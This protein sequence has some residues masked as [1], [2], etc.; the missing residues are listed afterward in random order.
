MTDEIRI[1][2]FVP[3][4]DPATIEDPLDDIVDGRKIIDLAENGA[5]AGYKIDGLDMTGKRITLP[6][7][8]SLAMNGRNAPGGIRRIWD[9]I[10]DERNRLLQLDP[11]WY[12]TAAAFDAAISAIA[13]IIPKT[14]WFDRLRMKYGVTT[15]TELKALFPNIT[16]ENLAYVVNGAPVDGKVEITVSWTPVDGAVGYRLYNHG[17]GFAES[18]TASYTRQVSVDMEYEIT[19]TAVNSDNIESDPS[20]PFTVLVEG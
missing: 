14:V 6:H 20:E 9:K 17:T 2:P 4:V 13:V 18:A 11:R 10:M 1:Y 8:L 19:V 5:P 15:W 12:K 3:V 7:I 16:V